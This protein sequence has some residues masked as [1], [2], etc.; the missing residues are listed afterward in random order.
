[1][2]MRMKIRMKMKM[3]IRIII[4]GKFNVNKLKIDL[5]ILCPLNQTGKVKKIS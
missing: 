5:L 1:M 4:T 3:K 2:K